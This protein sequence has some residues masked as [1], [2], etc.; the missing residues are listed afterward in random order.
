VKEL[1][2]PERKVRPLV[3]VAQPRDLITWFGDNPRVRLLGVCSL[4]L[5]G[6]DSGMIRG[7]L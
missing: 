5:G 4:L 7:S 1:G 2:V 3:A 6:L